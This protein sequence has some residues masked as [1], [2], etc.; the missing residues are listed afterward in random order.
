MKSFHTIGVCRP[1]KHYMVDISKKVDEIIHLVDKGAYFTINRPRQYGK[2]STLKLLKQRL[3]E[4]HTV[5]STSLSL[6]SAAD[7]AFANV[8]M[9]VTSFLRKIR[10]CMESADCPE[11]LT[12][13]W[14]DLSSVESGRDSLN[15]ELLQEKIDALCR[16]SERP[17]VLII[18]DTDSA[19]NSRVF[20][21][22]LGMLRDNYLRS[23]MDEEAAFQSVILAGTA[24]IKN[25][26]ST[27]R[28]EE[29]HTM[30]SPWNI[31]ADFHVDMSFSTEEIA[32][33]LQ[34][35]EADHQTGMDIWGM[36][37]LLREYTSGYPYLVS[38]ICQIMDENMIGSPGFSTYSSVWTREGF[39]SAEKRIVEERN[40]LFDELGRQIEGHPSLAKLL[41]AIL[42][43]GIPRPFSPDSSTQQLGIMYGLLAKQ[44]T[45]VC[46]SNRIFQDKL[47][48]C[49]L[50]REAL[51]SVLSGSAASS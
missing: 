48:S 15:F 7:E 10:N 33:M 35:Y 31:A 17:V 16:T 20:Q 23:Q 45:S 11:S 25:R 46:I 47:Y 26:K 3:A 36:S 1:E 49:Y 42:F 44:D 40:A 5:L 28:P 39:L 30:R 51:S 6:Q 37:S 13:A 50:G 8:P 2:T 34:E 27:D 24:D 22:F 18:D 38:R 32:G 4:S 43:E 21:E 14:M 41:H 12:A 9:F 19:A 29:G